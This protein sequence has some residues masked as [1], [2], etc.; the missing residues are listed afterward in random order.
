MW[1]LFPG[2][3]DGR[4]KDL[5]SELIC[6]R[7]PALFGVARSDVLHCVLFSVDLFSLLLGVVDRSYINFGV[8]RF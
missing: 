7:V 2:A 8:A 3:S 4:P 1:L 5:L 6:I